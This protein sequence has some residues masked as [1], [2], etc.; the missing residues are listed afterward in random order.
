MGSETSSL[1]EVEEEFSDFQFLKVVITERIKLVREMVD[2]KQAIVHDT[3]K[4]FVDGEAAKTRI[5]VAVFQDL[6]Y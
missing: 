2:T 6:R 1:S 4:Q 5:S 3:T